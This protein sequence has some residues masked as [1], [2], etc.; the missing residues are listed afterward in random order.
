MA[1]LLIVLAFGL[2]AAGAVPAAAAT[3]SY[4][5]TDLGSLGYDTWCLDS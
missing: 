2:V 4:T 5:M 3:S 1:K